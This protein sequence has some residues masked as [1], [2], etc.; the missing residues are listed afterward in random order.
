MAVMIVHIFTF[1]GINPEPWEVGP[2][3]W[4]T[5]PGTG[6]RVPT[7]GPSARLVNYQK[8]LKIELNRQIKIPVPATGLIRIEFFFWRRLDSTVRAVGQKSD[9][10]ISDA[11]NMQKAAEDA[12]QGILIVNDNQVKDL[13]SV[14]V[15][16]GP[17]VQPGIILKIARISE[18]SPVTIGDDLLARFNYERE[19]KYDYAGLDDE[20]RIK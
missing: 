4:R 18:Y 1:P 19:H 15:D 10:K 7:I 8:A 13:R 11:T 2:V 6:R 5:E 17:D 14:I 3:A 12:L 16:E 9:A 20:L